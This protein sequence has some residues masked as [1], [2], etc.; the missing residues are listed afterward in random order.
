MESVRQMPV[1]EFPAFIRS[2]LGM[3]TTSFDGK[4]LM[5]IALEVAQNNY[6]IE[7]YS[8]INEVEYWGGI[9]GKERYFYC[10]YDLNK[11]SDVIYRIIYEDLYVSGYPD[12]DVEPTVPEQTEKP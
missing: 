4:E 5:D 1:T 7:S 8:I 9:L 3:C 6:T 10:V 2:C 11:A 12:E